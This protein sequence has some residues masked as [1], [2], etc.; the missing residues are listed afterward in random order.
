MPVAGEGGEGRWLRVERNESIANEGA[1]VLAKEEPIGSG[2]QFLLCF[3]DESVGAN[4]TE[5]LTVSRDALVS[6]P[7][8]TR[9]RETPAVTQRSVGATAV[10]AQGQ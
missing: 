5:V 7:L 4:D 9:Q 6:P 10:V 8:H 3:V 1:F 2:H